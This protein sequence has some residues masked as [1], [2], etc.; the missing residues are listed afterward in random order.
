MRKIKSKRNQIMALVLVI[1][2]VASQNGLVANGATVGK[3]L[4][5]QYKAEWTMDEVESDTD[6][7]VLE[8]TGR[9]E[10]DS[11][12]TKVACEV[13][14]VESGECYYKGQEA[15]LTEG[16][17]CISDILLHDGQNK[18]VV[19]ATDCYGQRSVKETSVNYHMGELSCVGTVSTN[20]DGISYVDDQMVVMFADGVS[21]SRRDEVLKTVE[22]TVIG[23]LNTLDLVQVQVEVRSYK[24]LTQKCE[25]LMEYEEV[26]DVSI[27]YVTEE[28]ED[29][30][31]PFQT[32]EEEYA[33]SWQKSGGRN[34]WLKMIEAPEAWKYSAQL[35]ECKVGIVD[36]GFCVDHEDLVENIVDYKSMTN[37]AMD[38]SQKS[39]H[40][41]HVAGIIGA[42]ADNGVGIAGIN[43]KAKLYLRSTCDGNT[44][45]QTTSSAYAA[46]TDLVENQGVKVVNLSMGRQI[47]VEKVPTS[48][49]TAA[50]VIGK[51]LDKGYD[52]LLVQSAGNDGVDSVLNGKFASITSDTEV[53]GHT[54]EEVQ[55]HKIIVGNMTADKKLY[56]YMKNRSDGTQVESGS[57]YGA[58]VDIVAPGKSIYSCATV[59]DGV[60]TYQNKTGTSMAAPM[61]T[62]V[63]SLV[64]SADP[65]LTAAEVK[66][67]VLDQT[68]QVAIS[69]F[70][71]D[72]VES[73][74]VV[75]AKL[76]VRAALGIQ[77]D[78][79]VVEL[80]E[81]EV[82]NAKVPKHRI[83]KIKS[84]KVLKKGLLRI[85]WKKNT[86]YKKY[87]VWTSAKKKS[88]YKLVK[89]VKGNKVT[90][91]KGKQAKYIKIY[92]VS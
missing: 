50:K 65:S 83:I 91:K 52:F 5:K 24:E 2:S 13:T 31:D 9:F 17:W 51:L 23:E 69:D 3:F 4:T 19:T 64:W 62:G 60:S 90:L 54:I 40:G 46:V 37:S 75:N 72:T 58:N 41:T 80:Q 85:T 76:A 20:K 43:P 55:A 28:E 8:L 81:E 68:E 61:V 59:T 89:T 84:K 53:D 49:K 45:M 78:E 34:W 74:K 26:L 14:D 67:I 7:V 77:E 11:G 42:Q 79:T 86:K 36:V 32:P 70:S 16:S 39:A 35:Q 71:N 29:V 87:K 44:G 56:R 63:A 21:E 92:G 25:Q 33:L 18:I 57:N 48:A 10:K 30:N 82:P 6:E 47:S 66:Q 27:D 1:A 22:G 88:G 38:A 73:Y 15:E 12:I